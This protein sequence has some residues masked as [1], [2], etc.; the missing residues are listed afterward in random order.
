MKKVRL[1]NPVTG[2]SI[3]LPADGT[4]RRV[5]EAN[6]Y[7]PDDDL[8]RADGAATEMV[9]AHT[10]DELDEIARSRGV[11]PDGYRTKKDLAAALV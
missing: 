2:H 7:L 11:D 10:R 8:D 3:V 4:T 9:A 1:T 6:G 5:F